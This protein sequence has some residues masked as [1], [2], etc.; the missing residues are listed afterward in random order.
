V[1]RTEHRGALLRGVVAPLVLSVCFGLPC[2][3]Q[4][5]LETVG[6]IE[7]EHVVVSGT[8]SVQGDG[9]RNVTL[10]ASGAAVTVSSGTARLTL[11]DGGEIDL[12]GPAQF[13]VLKS[14]GSITIALD[15]G[16]L[17]MRIAPAGGIRVFTAL[18]VAEPVSVGGA[19]R[20]VVIGLD[21]EGTLCLLAYR[22]AVRLEQQLTGQVTVVPESSEL[23]VPGGRLEAMREA[24]SACRCEAT[25]DR[26]SAAASTGQLAAAISRSSGPESASKPATPAPA[27]IEPPQALPPPEEEP[28]WKVMLP[29]LTF[30]AKHPDA[31]SPAPD[32]IV[33][34]RQV[35]VSPEV[36]FSGR[37]EP[38]AASPSASSAPA[39]AT[40]NTAAAP[41]K[42]SAGFFARV[43]GFFRRLF[44]RKSS[45]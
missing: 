15:R 36:T 24:H 34:I 39:A 44:G 43:G 33:L 21:A 3:A 2:A 38:Q 11:A 12:C 42:E 30:D 13:R 16:A 28:A 6:R 41:K 29:P 18:V 31:P 19:A 5:A 40:A 14:G 1:A 35:R 32:M 37:V 4:G 22:G 20:D 10:L 8:V 23:V 9:G 17:H 25:F 26:P 27:K 45:S 7:G